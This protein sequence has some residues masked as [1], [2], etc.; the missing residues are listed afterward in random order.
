MYRHEN[1]QCA[2]IYIYILAYIV[3]MYIYSRCH[4][5]SFSGRPL[6]F[7]Y[8]LS[9]M[10]I[11]IG[12]TCIFVCERKREKDRETERQTETDTGRGRETELCVLR[13]NAVVLNRLF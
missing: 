9:M 2:Y 1:L 5:L 13:L 10:H 12:P 11:Y 3:I 6:C 4:N 8:S 7:A